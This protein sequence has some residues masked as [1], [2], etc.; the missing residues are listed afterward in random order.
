[1]KAI[2][3]RAGGGLEHLEYGEWPDPVLGAGEVLVKVGAAACNRSDVWLRRGMIG[4]LP[5]VPGLDGAGRVA[6]MA[7]DVS[8]LAMGARVLL[9]PATTCDACEYCYAGEHGLCH[10]RKALGQF[11]DGTFAEYVKVPWRNVHLIRDSLSFEEAAAIPSAFFTA[12]QLLV[13]R[14]GVAPWQTVLI[15]AAGSG[16][17]SASIQIAKLLGA[18]V[19]A[20]AGSATKLERSEEW[21]AD[22]TINYTD[23]D[24]PQRVLDLT[25]GKGAHVIID[26]VGG[27]FWKGYMECARIGGRIVACSYT[28]GRTPSVEIETLMRRQISIIGSGGMGSKAEAKKVVHLVNEGRLRGVVD[29][30]FPLKD[31]A[32]A[33]AAMEDRSVIGK[34][35]LVPG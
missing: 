33:Q 35:V 21:G 10:Q 18:R 13:L 17:G 2:I 30:V 27:A 22:E 3:A 19:I 14:G 24:W 8:G 7:A 15:M 1:M 28:T 26:A 5:M 31:A 6:D 16:V 25:D 4:P 12:W 29:R 32:L 34:I 20:A 11:L 9:N 23:E